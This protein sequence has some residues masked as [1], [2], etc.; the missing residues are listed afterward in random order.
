MT[1]NAKITIVSQTQ[2]K[3]SVRRILATLR[4]GTAEKNPLFKPKDIYNQC[5]YQRQVQLGPYSLLQVLIMALNKR[6]DY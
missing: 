1:D 4:L 5:T 3:S 2:V 6:K